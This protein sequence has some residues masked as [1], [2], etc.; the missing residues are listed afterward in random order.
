MRDNYSMNYQT[1]ITSPSPGDS[2]DHSGMPCS[3][4]AY[5]F[6]KEMVESG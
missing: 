4:S 3:L 6:I 1:L 5:L 2:T